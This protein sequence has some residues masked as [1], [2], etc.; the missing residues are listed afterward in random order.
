MQA[1]CQLAYFEGCDGLAV[2]E[3]AGGKRRHDHRF[4]AFNEF[5]GSSFSQGLPFP[6]QAA[7][8]PPRVEAAALHGLEFCIS[9]QQ[10]NPDQQ[11]TSFMGQSTIRNQCCNQGLWP[12]MQAECGWAR[13]LG[14]RMFERAIML[15]ARML[16]LPAGHIAQSMLIQSR[17]TVNSTWE[18]SV[19]ELQ[20]GVGA[21]AHP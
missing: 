11:V 5:R 7:A 15:R 2:S 3:E 14:T 12:L 13:R 1:L 8:I 19:A 6:L 17:A 20:S 16:L 4:E 10:R 18:R 9:T 21:F